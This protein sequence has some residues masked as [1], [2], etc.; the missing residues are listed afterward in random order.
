MDVEEMPISPLEIALMAHN[1]MR[2]KEM[3]HFK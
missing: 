1:V 3:L 2:Q